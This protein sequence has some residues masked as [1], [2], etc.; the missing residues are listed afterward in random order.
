MQLQCTRDR[1]L[2]GD[3]APVVRM[4]FA[5]RRATDLE[6]EVAEHLSRRDR[7]RARE[8]KAQQLVLLE[9]ALEAGQRQ[10]LEGGGDGSK[11]LELLTVV[12]ERARQVAS[13]LEDDEEDVE[14]M[15]KQCWQDR[16]DFSNASIC[17]L[18]ERAD[19]S[20]SGDDVG[21]VADLAA[22]SPRGPPSVS[23]SSTF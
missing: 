8:V 13:R 16:D 5:L 20:H 17:D 3:E 14:L 23:S 11:D 1:T 21:N 6:R 7:Q 22:L 19:S 10:L 18:R 12:L 9:G 2:I 15:A 4:A